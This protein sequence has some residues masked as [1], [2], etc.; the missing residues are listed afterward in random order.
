MRKKTGSF[1]VIPFIAAAAFSAQSCTK[2]GAE[3][4]GQE[5]KT[6]SPG[7]PAEVALLPE[8][9]KAGT[10]LRAVV[11]GDAVEV[12]W[13]RNGQPLATEGD[14]LLTT[15]FRK[16]DVIRVVAGPAGSERA[17]EAVLL[18]APPVIRSVTIL[19][20][21]FYKGQDIVAEVQGWDPDGD[22]ISYKYEWTV[23]GERVYETDGH[24]LSGGSY[25]RGDAI[26]VK[27][28]PFDGESE[29]E[30]FKAEAGQAGNSPPR[31][32]STPPADFSGRFLYSPVV[33]DPDGDSVALS[34]ERSPEG[35]AIGNGVI[36]WRA[37]DDQNGS[38]EVTIAA[39]DG[40]GG[41]ALQTFELKVGQ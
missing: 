27:V 11:S 22:S 33:S 30:S 23:N 8:A 29:G 17:A 32:T 37:K 7:A 31:F 2:D 1:I 3:K 6:G 38:F 21:P 36:E 35:M 24:V 10:M 4:A 12:R 9:P 40:S 13:L 28:V 15:G 16:G 39:E 34:L 41:K 25:G 5:L 26:A 14:T 18:N 20:R 19:P